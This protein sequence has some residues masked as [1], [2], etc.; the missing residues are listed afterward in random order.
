MQDASSRRL[1]TQKR[2]RK[3]RDNQIMRAMWWRGMSILFA[4]FNFQSIRTPFMGQSNGSRIVSAP[5]LETNE[6]K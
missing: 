2:N 3:K 5:K 4:I 6:S 1:K